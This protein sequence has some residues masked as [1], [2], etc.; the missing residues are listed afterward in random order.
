MILLCTENLN[1][2][3]IN[4]RIL[5][6]LQITAYRGAAYM[7]SDYGAEVL[8]SIPVSP[9]LFYLIFTYWR[10]GRL[11]T[12]WPDRVDFAHVQTG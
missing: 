5:H 6:V 3:M 12:P 8:R 1:F 11:S 2:F 4:T 9:T 10:D 7:T